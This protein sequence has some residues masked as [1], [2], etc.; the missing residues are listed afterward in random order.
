MKKFIITTESGSD[1]SEE[2]IKRYDIHIVPM[3]LSLGDRTID[4]GSVP[5]EEIFQFYEKSNILPKTSGST[6]EDY[7]FIF[8]KLVKKYPGAQIINIA[9]SAVTSVSYNSCRIAAE[10]FPNVHLVD[11]KNVSAGL[12]AIVVSTAQFIEKNPDVSPQEVVAFV[13]E[14]RERTHFLFLPQS[15]NYLRAGGR[16]SNVQFLGAS[17]LKILPT[18]VL[19]DGYL[20]AS[21]KYRGSFQRSI[22]K[23][24]LDFLNDYDIEPGTVTVGGTPRL[25]ESDIAIAITELSSH[26]FQNPQIFEA[27]AVIASHGGP[28]AFGLV[29]IEKKKGK[30]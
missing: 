21:K 7:R 25:S 14:I 18:I 5:V 13:E 22:K 11:S 28:G 16:V 15:L 20:V 3:H 9:Y 12:A 1:L 10:A 2:L 29:G 8:E 26:N 4:D 24:V 17:V 23:M 30:D 6:P 19:K 27:G